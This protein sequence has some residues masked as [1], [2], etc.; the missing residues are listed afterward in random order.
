MKMHDQKIRIGNKV[1]YTCVND[2][3]PYGD[4]DTE[5]LYGYI[6]Y[7]GEDVKV[8]RATK[9]YDKQGNVSYEWIEVRE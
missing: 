9:L 8:C 2:V 1:V 5:Y 6:K 3:H 7:M 4:S